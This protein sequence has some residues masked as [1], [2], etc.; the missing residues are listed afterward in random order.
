MPERTSTPQVNR[1][2][3]LIA[4]LLQE[5]QVLDFDSVCAHKFGQVSAFAVTAI[6]FSLADVGEKT[7]TE[8]PF[9]I[10]ERVGRNDALPDPAMELV[11]GAP[12]QWWADSR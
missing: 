7:R 3:S 9:Q 8:R 6:Q 10:E 1:L 12:G 2:L 4:D 11:D 5:V